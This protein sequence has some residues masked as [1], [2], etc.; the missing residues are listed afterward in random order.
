MFGHF[1][2]TCS[3]N[4]KPLFST[5]INQIITAPH[6]KKFEVIYKTYIIDKKKA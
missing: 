6:L 5:Y 4:I 3:N 1:R 2:G